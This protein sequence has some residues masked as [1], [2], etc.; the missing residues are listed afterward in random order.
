MTWFLLTLTKHQFGPATH[1]MP[2]LA[3]QWLGLQCLHCGRVSGL[4]PWQIV[5][6]PVGMATCAKSP[7]RMGVWEW[8]RDSINCLAPGWRNG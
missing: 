1:P 5:Q 7:V 3:P 6:M 2:D 4:D 8:V